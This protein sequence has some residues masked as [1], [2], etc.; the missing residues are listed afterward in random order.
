VSVLDDV[1]VV[2]VRKS[3]WA[4]PQAERW[5]RRLYARVFYGHSSNRFN[6]VVVTLRTL[7]AVW[8]RRPRLIVLG[9]VERATSWL[10][11]ARGLGLLRGTPL[12]VTNHL[13]LS[14]A[15][16]AQVECVILY[17]R[18]V[19]EDARPALRDRATFIPLPADGD[20][21]AASRNG[22]GT[23][24]VFAGGGADRDFASLIRAVEGTPIQ[25]EIVTFDPAMLGWEGE[26]PANVTV[27]WRMPLEAFLPRLARSEFVVVPLRT[28]GSP[29]GQTTVVQALA[30]G[31][32]V[33]ATRTPGVLDYVEDG[34]EGLLVEPGDIEGYRTSATRLS[35]DP[36][37][38]QA[39]EQNARAKSAMLTYDVFGD[40]LAA[41]CKE[42]VDRA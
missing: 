9:S 33:V 37:F 25:L 39:C 32:A 28:P 13:D 26:L 1:L 11:R 2:T 36:D 42:L 21:A 41:L 17:A 22:T 30:L 19:I 16:L 24:R 12:V 8:I 7:L 40:R 27:H 31:K 23:G 38:R 5:P 14:D 34:K 6:S 15:E 20:F 4:S 29:H 18:P 3:F 10:I 35:E